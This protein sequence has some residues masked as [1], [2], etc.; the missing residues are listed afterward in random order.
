[1]FGRVSRAANF[2]PEFRAI[3]ATCMPNARL[4]FSARYGSALGEARLK[5][6]C[7]VQNCGLNFFPP[8]ENEPF[9]D[10]VTRVS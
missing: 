9:A 6:V 5:Q 1:M 10:T 2:V 7:F 4:A 3:A 8:G